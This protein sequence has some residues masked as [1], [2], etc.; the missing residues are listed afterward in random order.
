LIISFKQK[1]SLNW[2]NVKFCGIPQTLL[3]ELK[4]NTKHEKTFIITKHLNIFVDLS[5]K[6]HFQ[7]TKINLG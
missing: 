6:T 4:I 1:R 2:L 5:T 3:F 7:F